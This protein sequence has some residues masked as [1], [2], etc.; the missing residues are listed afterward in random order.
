MDFKAKHTFLLETSPLATNALLLQPPIDTALIQY[1]STSL[2]ALLTARYNESYI[3]PG[4][5]LQNYDISRTS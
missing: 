2:K 3:R 5:I 4:I 1:I